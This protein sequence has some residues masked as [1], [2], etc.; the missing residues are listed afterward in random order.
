MR[1][2]TILSKERI[3][4]GR[5]PLVRQRG[6][7]KGRLGKEGSQPFLMSPCSYES[8]RCLDHAKLSFVAS[9]ENV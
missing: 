6:I 2:A 3:C 9:Q 8:F 7:Y 4:K 5:E 1:L